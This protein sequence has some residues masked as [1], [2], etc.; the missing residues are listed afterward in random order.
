MKC[1]EIVFLDLDETLMDFKA[2]EQAALASSF[3]EFGLQLSSETIRLYEARNTTLWKALERGEID[4]ERLKVERF[5]Q[6]FQELGWPVDPATFSAVYIEFLS[7]GIYPLPQVEE[8]CAYLSER[9]RLAI[10]TNGIAGVQYPRILDSGIAQYIE[11][12]IVSE[13]AG[14][15]KPNPAIFEYGCKRLG[16]HDKAAMLMV[17]DSLVSDIQG[18]VNFGIDSCW[19]NVAGKP[20]PQDGPQPSY[21][22]GSLAELRNIV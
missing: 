8:T 21:E 22:I 2:A 5:R 6:V 4:Q 18:A 1:Y 16:F 14:F 3:E 13:E 9:Y 20:V 17:G 15:S 7:H 19:L 10:V 11:A 12:I